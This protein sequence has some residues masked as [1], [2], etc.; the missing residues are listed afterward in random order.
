[1]KKKNMTDRT[2]DYITMANL[3]IMNISMWTLLVCGIFGNKGIIPMVTIIIY[4]ISNISV[5]LELEVNNKIIGFITI[6]T[7]LIIPY[8]VA[9]VIRS[10]VL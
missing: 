2:K 10:I 1:M 8:I 7:V 9:L 4:T 3:V 5:L 6:E